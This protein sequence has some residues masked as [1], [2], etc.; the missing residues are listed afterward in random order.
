MKGFPQTRK[1]KETKNCKCCLVGIV[2][3]KWN[4]KKDQLLVNFKK[5]LDILGGQ[6]SILINEWNG[7]V[8]RFVQGVG[9]SDL[10][11]RL[12]GGPVLECLE[13]GGNNCSHFTPP[14]LI[15]TPRKAQDPLLAGP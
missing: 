5:E 11:G 12:P 8:N 2:A 6:G 3:Q 15:I 4:N 13:L 10:E 1:R 14:E 7:P 9:G